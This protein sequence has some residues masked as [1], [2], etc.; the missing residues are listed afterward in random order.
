MNKQEIILLISN[1]FGVDPNEI[2][3]DADFYED[4]NKEKALEQNKKRVRKEQ[5]KR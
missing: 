5:N 2:I 3:P 1:V 4:F